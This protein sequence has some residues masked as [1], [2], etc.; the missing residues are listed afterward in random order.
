VTVELA[1]TA[2]VLFLILMAAL[3][4]GH[5]NMVFNTIEAACYEGARVGIV[6]GATSADCQTAA[7]QI[8][9]TAR[10]SGAR[11]RVTPAVLDSTAATVRVQIDVP[12]SFNAIT[13]PAFTR[14]LNIQ[15]QCKLTRERP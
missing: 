10:V 12:Y 9:N 6:P 11:V 15:R 1:M 2:P 3:E 14:G 5:A 7:Q 13:V 4:L 8:L